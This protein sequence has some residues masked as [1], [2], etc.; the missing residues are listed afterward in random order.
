M[1]IQKYEFVLSSQSQP[2]VNVQ[3]SFIPAALLKADSNEMGKT[4]KDAL[5]KVLYNEPTPIDVHKDFRFV[6]R[7]WSQKSFA[8]TNSKYLEFRNSVKKDLNNVP[9]YHEHPKKS[10]GDSL[11]CNGCM[12]DVPGYDSLTWAQ[13]NLWTVAG[14][15]L[16]S[17]EWHNCSDLINSPPNSLTVAAHKYYK[18]ALVL[19]SINLMA[20]FALGKDTPS[21][22]NTKF[23]LFSAI[24]VAGSLAVKS[25]VLSNDYF[26]LYNGNARG[27]DPLKL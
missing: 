26:G 23:L 15:Y 16:H 21:D 20:R 1:F 13:K 8:F 17:E 25:V 2:I 11:V 10:W 27:S 14:R 24:A 6:P 22:A 9:T 4:F 3:K 7:D 18:V 12:D 5:T 19:G